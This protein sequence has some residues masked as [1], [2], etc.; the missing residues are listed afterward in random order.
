MGKVSLF[1]FFIPKVLGI[2]FKGTGRKLIESLNLTL[3]VSNSMDMSF[4]SF[5]IKGIKREFEEY[6]NV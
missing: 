1:Q 5:R 3:A 6:E 4:A 2:A